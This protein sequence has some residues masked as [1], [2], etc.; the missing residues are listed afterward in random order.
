MVSKGNY[1]YSIYVGAS[2]AWFVC[3]VCPIF[4]KLTSTHPHHTYNYM[5]GLEAS[6]NMEN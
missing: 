5:N 4:S 6:V 1:Y 2:Y 3:F